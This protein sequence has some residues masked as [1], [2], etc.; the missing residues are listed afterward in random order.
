[1]NGTTS[2]PTMLK[3][4]EAVH[5]RLSGES[6]AD[7]TLLFEVSDCPVPGLYP[8]TIGDSLQLRSPLKVVQSRVSG[9]VQ[10]GHVFDPGNYTQYAFAGGGSSAYRAHLARV[11]SSLQRRIGQK[12]AK[13]LEVGCGDGSLITMLREQGFAHAYGIDP[14][15]AAHARPEDY[16]ACGFFPHDL[17]P[18]W[19]DGGFDVMIARHVLE[20][21]ETPTSF[22]Q[23]MAAALRPGGLLCIEVPDLDSTL[24]RGLWSN[25]YQL[26]CNYFSELTLDGMMAALGF[27]CIEGSVVEIFGGSLLRLYQRGNPPAIPAPARIDHANA[28]VGAFQQELSDLAEQLPDDA[29]GYGAAERTAMTLGL[30]PTLVNRLQRLFDGNPLLHQR[31]LAGTRL[32]IG[33]C[34][35]LYQAPPSSIVI[36]AI[37]NAAEIIGNFRRNLPGSTLIGLAG[38]GTNLTPLKDLA[39]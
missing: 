14:S 16:I 4:Q 33:S 29:V 36:F 19:A 35:E 30:C 39:S 38:R 15:L 2:F 27:R 17:P 24:Q 20:H 11:A 34:A 5:C 9:F 37:S 21:I 13:I 22:L 18:N 6:L 8:T 28:R 32:S 23:A 31:Y 1:M 25:F 12:N 26:H 10:L 3:L 7:A